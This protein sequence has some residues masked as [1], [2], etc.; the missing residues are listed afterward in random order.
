MGQSEC[1]MSGEGGQ[2]KEKG[3]WQCVQVRHLLCQVGAQG[4]TTTLL[5][6]MCLSGA[7]RTS[8]NSWALNA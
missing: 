1:L 8:G 3:S 6:H 5:V 4:L 2:G 7:A